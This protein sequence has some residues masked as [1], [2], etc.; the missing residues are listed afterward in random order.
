MLSPSAVGQGER[1]DVGQRF[2][3]TPHAE[4]AEWEDEDNLTLDDVAPKNRAVIL[5]GHDMGDSWEHRL[6]VEKIGP[7]ES[8]TVY[9]RCVFGARACPSEDCGGTCGY[10]N[11]LEAIA[12]P[13]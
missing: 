7:P 12:S 11:L 3:G 1:F 6:I 2:F 5:Y 8:G 13:D 4:T 9:P 10:G